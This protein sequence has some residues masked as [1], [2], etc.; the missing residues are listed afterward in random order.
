MKK[1]R[2]IT[3]KVWL[4]IERYDERTGSG[5]SMDAP[6]ASL[7]SFGDYAE[8]WDYAERVAGLAQAIRI[9]P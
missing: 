2:H 6:G 5:E 9:E 3:Y 8:A 1:Q 4:E 7:A